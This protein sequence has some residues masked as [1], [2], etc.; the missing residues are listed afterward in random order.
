[1]EPLKVQALLL[2]LTSEFLQGFEHPLLLSPQRRD[3]D[4]VRAYVLDRN[5]ARR[6]QGV[7]PSE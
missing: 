3:Q 7:L 4:G 1:M 2:N 6:W 5:Q